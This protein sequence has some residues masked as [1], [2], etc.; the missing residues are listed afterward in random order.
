MA[1]F[2][3]A[4]YN[5][6]RCKCDSCWRGRYN[7]VCCCVQF[8]GEKCPVKDCPDYQ[9]RPEEKEDDHE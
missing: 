1:G 8:P 7:A 6:A 2:R 3:W 5:A 9:P 4:C